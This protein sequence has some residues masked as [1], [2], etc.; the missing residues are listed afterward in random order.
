MI[1]TRSNSL[2]LKP[3]DIQPSR[4]DF[5]V[6]G[7]FN[8]AVAMIGDELY[9]LARVAE[10]A[11]ESRVGWTALPLQTLSGTIEIEWFRDVDLHVVDARVVALKKNDDLRL[12]SVSHMQLFRST[13]R[14]GTDWEFVSAILPEGR[15]ETYGIEDPR[16]TKIESTFWIT[17]VAVSPMGAATALMS[18]S[19]FVTFDR[20]G[21]IFSCEN[22]DVVLFPSRIAGDFVALHRP[23]PHSHFSPPQIWLARSPDLIHWGRHEFVLGGMHAWEG[24]RV[25]S[26]TPP[27]LCDEGWLTLYH[28][29][30]RSNIA[31]TVGCY[32]AGALL[33]DRDQPSRVLARTSEPIMQPAT[34]FEK[35][36]FVPNVVFPTA[37]LDRGDELQIFYGAADTCVASAQFSKQSVLDSLVRQD[38]SK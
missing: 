15:W 16:I 26:G 27:I 6:V 10:R 11:A 1:E 5:E 4:D 3:S 32:S 13:N 30:N 22:K 20:H 28:G 8:P 14:S 25:G 23:N 33:L 7:V 29:S 38:Q 12:T 19:N 2:L 37:M 18:T 34:E 9:M 17:Y 24:D 31:G 35:N 21:I 36:G